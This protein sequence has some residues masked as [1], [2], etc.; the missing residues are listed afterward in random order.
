M[1]LCKYACLP[2]RACACMCLYTWCVCL[3][4]ARTRDARTLKH[5]TLVVTVC[6][7]AHSFAHTHRHRY[8]HTPPCIYAALPGGT[9][10]DV[11]RSRENTAS[12]NTHTHLPPHA[13]VQRMH[14]RTRARVKCE[15][16][17][18]NIYTSSSII[19]QQ[20]CMYGFVCR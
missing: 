16:T 4:Y 13:H 12:T 1:Y 3:P 9:G 20:K 19:E 5:T 2:E 15:S 6:F 8:T 17:N 7:P 14:M 10:N 18:T 11:V